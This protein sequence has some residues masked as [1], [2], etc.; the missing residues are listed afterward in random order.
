MALYSYQAYNKEG[1]KVTGT[2][3][4]GS[5]PSARE[6]LAKMSMYPIKIELVT[7][8]GTVKKSWW[9]TLFSRRVSIKDK[10]FFTKQLSVLLKAGVPLLQALDLL[11]DQNEGR[12]KSIT[13]DLKDTIKEG[14]SLA[15]GLAKYPKVFD[16][17]Y[18]QLV[19]AGEASGKLETILDR[20]VIFLQTRD[21][22]RK[23]VR[24]ALS[25]PLIQLIIV[26]LVVIVL[27][28]FV[29]PQITEIFES[30]A[31]RLPLTTT[32][33]ITMS[34]FLINHYLILIMILVAIVS[35][36]LYWSSTQVGRR[37]IDKIKLKIPLVKYFVK[38]ST[39]VQF[40]R[41]L[42]MLLE[43]GVNLSEA[44]NIVTKVVDNKILVDVLNE[45][46]ENIIKQG[47]ISQYLKQTGL[48]PPLAIYLINTGEQ[49]GHLD[50]MLLTVAEIYEK[51][52]SELSDS[53]SSKIGPIM[54]VV[55]AFVVGFVIFAIATP[56]MQLTQVVAK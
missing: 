30:Q 55:M 48:F 36:Y 16:N 1:K 22:L 25:Y 32:I 28:T 45:A 41:T 19:R 37:T 51:E 13:I 6:M 53:L 24:G 42:G 10:I 34:D 20:L 4:A 47:K 11:V 26:A 49:S 27:L 23:K 38:M 52:L 21:E 43:S 56:L 35:L 29:V 40:S 54:L 7:E 18:I 31:T 3:D 8:Q 5:L 17:I 50:T 46:K 33:L 12:L 15:D 14:K 2:L 44:L 39:I 9:A